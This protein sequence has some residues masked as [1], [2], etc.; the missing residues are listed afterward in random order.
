MR[1]FLIEE[2]KIVKKVRLNN[3]AAL[4]VPVAAATGRRSYISSMITNLDEMIGAQG[5]TSI[6]DEEALDQGARVLSEGGVSSAAVIMGPWNL[7]VH[8]CNA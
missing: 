8:R 1:A 2:Q 5:V 6:V 4:A 3:A 7:C